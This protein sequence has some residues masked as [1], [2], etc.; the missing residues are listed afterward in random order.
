MRCTWTRTK[1]WSEILQ[2]PLQLFTSVMQ[3]FLLESIMTVFLIFNYSLGGF[4]FMF[5]YL[6][7]R[8]NA[9]LMIIPLDVANDVSLTPLLFELLWRLVLLSIWNI[10]FFNF[11]IKSPLVWFWSYWRYC[12]IKYF[13]L[14][15][16]LIFCLSVFCI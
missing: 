9:L 8:K 16:Q 6:F 7:C 15:I 11:P 14:F 2:T 12:I 5:M 3:Y 4:L 1:K 10:F 13:Q